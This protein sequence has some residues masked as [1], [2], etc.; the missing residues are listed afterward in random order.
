MTLGTP[1][2]P[3]ALNYAPQARNDL[4]VIAQ[5]QKGVIFCILGYFL[6]VLSQ[7]LLPPELRVV[8]MLAA[9]AVSITAVVFVFM[10][11]LALYGTGAG[12]VLGILTLIPIVGLIVLL[13]LNGK[14]TNIL[15]QHGV[16]VG[17]LGARAS[18]IPVATH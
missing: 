16:K 9:L 6:L 18:D 13:V 1:G 14:A 10:L 4:R 11:S 8:A 15:K 7:F 2:Q 12:I 3:P 5:R 17:L